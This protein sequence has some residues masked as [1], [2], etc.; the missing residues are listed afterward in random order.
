MRPAHHL[1]RWSWTLLP[2]ALVAGQASAASAL[3]RVAGP[4]RTVESAPAAQGRGEAHPVERAAALRQLGAPSASDRRQGAETL[5]RIG[6]MDDVT[7]LSPRLADDD[8]G[9]REVAQAAIWRIWSRSGD[10]KTDARF[11]RGVGQMAGGELLAALAT[12]T[13]IIE[14][15]PDFAEAWN[16]RATVYFLLGDYERSLRDCDEVFK[17]NPQHFGA[18]SGAAQMHLQMGHLD[19]ALDLLQRAKLANPG[20]TST[21]A[22]IEMLR[23]HQRSVRDRR[24]I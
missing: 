13:E 3:L 9:V 12:F 24:A 23:K 6:R 8:E 19:E 2:L 22:L 18:L 5:G 21:D 17:R 14:R 16:K 11:K 7:A 4:G 10:E 15:R 1:A 20:L